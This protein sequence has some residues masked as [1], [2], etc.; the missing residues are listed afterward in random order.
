MKNNWLDGFLNA[1]ENKI[2][3]SEQKETE[4]KL[5]EDITAEINIKDL[6]TI[7]W[8]DEQYRVLFNDDGTAE[9]LNEFGNHV[10]T[11]DGTTIDDINKQLG[12]R[13]IVVN[14]KLDNLLEKIA[15]FK[16]IANEIS[17][18]LL[19]IKQQY[20]RIDTFKEEEFDAKMIDYDNMIESIKLTTE[21]INE[22]N[23]IKFD[24]Y[25]KEFPVYDAKTEIEL[26]DKDSEIF[27]N[28]QC[29]YCKEFNLVK[30]TSDEN[31]QYIECKECNTKYKVDLNNGNIYLLVGDNNDNE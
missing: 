12:D 8:N 6:P 31:Y 28:T 19:N 7:I 10:K 17:D 2:T 5:D 3:T 30:T 1:F 29:P 25:N 27:K 21:K 18:D 14:N 9:L 24:N 23:R 22:D 20:A 13:Q 15:N 4:M 11:M 26:T 16:K